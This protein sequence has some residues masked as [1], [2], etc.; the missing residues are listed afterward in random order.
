MNGIQSENPLNCRKKTA[1]LVVFASPLGWIAQ[2]GHGNVLGRVTFAHPS[3]DAAIR[4]LDTKL[5]E[6]ARLGKWNDSLVQRL[7]AYTR[8]TPVDFAD[9]QLDLQRLTDFQRRVVRHCRNIPYGKTVTYGQL[10]AKAG[11]P[12][13]ARAVGNCMANNRFPLIVPCHR[14]V[15]AAGRMGGFSAPGGTRLKERLL[16]LEA[17]QFE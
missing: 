3:A 6:N 11:S 5:L 10:A 4:A 17:R 7:Q 9:V 1:T 12:R 16:A 14:V 2:V 15:S 8:G 13:A